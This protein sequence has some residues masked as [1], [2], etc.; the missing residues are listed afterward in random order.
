MGAFG[1][2]AEPRI[3]IISQNLNVNYK[4][5]ALLSQKSEELKNKQKF[6]K[7]IDNSDL[8]KNKAASKKN[9]E[10]LNILFE[11]INN[12]NKKVGTKSLLERFYNYTKIKKENLG[13]IPGKIADVKP[14]DYLNP[15]IIRQV[16]RFTNS[17][18]EI[19][20]KLGGLPRK[21][22]SNRL[23][24]TF[25]KDK[26]E[27]EREYSKSI[28]GLTQLFVKKKLNKLPDLRSATAELKEIN[29]DDSFI[30]PCNGARKAVKKKKI[31]IIN[32]YCSK[33]D[34][35]SKQIKLDFFRRS[36]DL[37]SLEKNYQMLLN[38]RDTNKS[39]QYIEKISEYK[40]RR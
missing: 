19:D 26:K 31:D 28:V 9:E 13:A 2:T 21:C 16:S 8:K 38:Q 14:T 25:I 6:M 17:T 24:C 18:V 4:I 37:S 10:N 39:Q 33:L 30:Q 5:T 20:Q 27:R 7:R 15:H 34:D 36:L 29:S 32:E 40:R 12:Q 3:I 35:P 23:S 1:S 11:K 22:E